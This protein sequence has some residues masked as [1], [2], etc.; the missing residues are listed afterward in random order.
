MSILLPSYAIANDAQRVTLGNFGLP[1]TLDLPT[2]RHFPDGEFVVTHQLH[3]SLARYGISFQALPWLGLSFRYTG[4]GNG[5]QLAYGRIHYD[6]SFDA[7]IS[8]LSETKY[9]PAL[10]IGLRDFIG[11]GVY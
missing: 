3:N 5:G 8:V 9:Q 6:R 4:H 1:G 11:T 2:A 10:S 7:H